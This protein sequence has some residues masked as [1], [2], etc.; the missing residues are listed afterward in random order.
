MLEP[1]ITMSTTTASHTPRRRRVAATAASL[2]VFGALLGMAA[3]TS[4]DDG[5]A[6]A[7]TVAEA[8]APP[9][10]PMSAPPTSPDV[11]SPT[12][13]APPQ[14][15]VRP[16]NAAA[17]SQPAAPTPTVA[18]DPAR[19]AQLAAILAEHQAAG[20]FVGARIAMRTA[21]GTITEASGGTQTLDPASGPID[22]DMPWN[23]GSATKTFVATVVLQ[24]ADEGR[25]DLDAG[26]DRYVTYLPGA[27]RITPR[28]LLNHTSGLGEYLDQPAT[29]A[30]PKRQWTP[31]E[32]VAIAEAAGRTGEPGGPHH[33]SNTNY[34]V[35]GDII[36]QVT[37][38]SW[39]DE[40]QDRIAEPLGMTHTGLTG[41]P[42]PAFAPG[43][44]TLVNVSDDFDPSIGGAAGALQST[45]R[46][47]LVF[48]KALTDGTLVSPQSQAAM[49]QFLPAEDLSRFG[50]DHGYG[51]G[52]E[53]YVMDG[54]TV[55]GHMGTGETGS[56]YVG[57]DA[58]TG[59]TV[60][61]TTNTAIAG[62]SAIMA[63]EALTAARA[64]G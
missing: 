22:P 50:I 21:D 60:A 20:E 30:E 63:I 13:A 17:P 12:T 11:L 49:Q 35:L 52:I 3:C 46:D 41:T 56:S 47:L 18:V 55:I 28:Q 5:S 23:I 9:T 64:A 10:T 2:A 57:Y 4:D 62:P 37:G 45:S 7:G 39:V 6:A 58:E 27:D 15:E 61:V 32:Q 31:A 33:Y 43:D 26:I 48:A 40:V 54:M 59:T 19:Q 1:M 51:L 34:I 16:T 24:L 53:R 36:E 42:V 44:G 14:L 8:S 38:Q 25:L 29:R